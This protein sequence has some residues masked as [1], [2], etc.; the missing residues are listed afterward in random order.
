VHSPVGKHPERY[1]VTCLRRFHTHS[2]TTNQFHDVTGIDHD[3][4]GAASRKRLY[5]YMH[6]SDL[7]STYA[8]GSSNVAPVRG[9]KQKGSPPRAR[10]CATHNGAA[11]LI[12]RR[13]PERARVLHRL[14]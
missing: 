1:G 7:I 6:A 5:N 3:V 8:N 11:K 4:F 14:Q 12:E 10:R 9:A 2:P 13:W